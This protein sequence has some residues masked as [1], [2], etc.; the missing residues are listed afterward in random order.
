MPVILEASA[1]CMHISPVKH[2]F[3]SLSLSDWNCLHLA[4]VL[5][6]CLGETCCLYN[7][8]D[9]FVHCLPVFL[10]SLLISVC[11]GVFCLFCFFKSYCVFGLFMRFCEVWW[12]EVNS[13]PCI[14]HLFF[15]H[16]I[17]N[18][19]LK[20]PRL[21]HQQNHER[22]ILTQRVIAFLLFYEEVIPLIHCSL[23]CQRYFSKKTHSLKGQWKSTFCILTRLYT[24][25]FTATRWWDNFLNDL[26]F[27]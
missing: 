11:Y 5:P 16:G 6:F 12:F 8:C 7:V 18:T 21:S 20:L 26:F 17:W 1:F 9:M 14:L 23:F 22:L 19:I 13:E 25:L 15:C 27:S 24:E 10:C 2:S 4:T 3:C